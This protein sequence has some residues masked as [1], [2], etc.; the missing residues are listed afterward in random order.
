RIAQ[1]V[2]WPPWVRGSSADGE[3]AAAAADVAPPALL[4]GVPP[5]HVPL[6]GPGGGLAGPGAVRGGPPVPQL[7]RVVVG[8]RAGGRPLAR[9]GPRWPNRRPRPVV[10]DGRAVGLCPAAA[11]A[12]GGAVT[13]TGAVLGI[14]GVNTRPLHAATL[15]I[16]GNWGSTLRPHL[17]RVT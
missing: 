17:D 13:A 4:C 11:R 9:P 10:P 8:P 1:S 5:A 12:G 16:A 7:P 2:I 6:P 14:A 15:G 3:A